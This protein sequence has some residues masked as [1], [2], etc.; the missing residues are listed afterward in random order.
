MQIKI[1]YL[2]NFNTYYSYHIITR[3]VSSSKLGCTR[4]GW[5][6]LSSIHRIIS[7]AI[8]GLFFYCTHFLVSGRKFFIIIHTL[9]TRLATSIEMVKFYVRWISIA[10]Y[11]FLN[12][13]KILMDTKVREECEDVIV[14][15]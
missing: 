4:I 2:P 11:L 13:L 9:R 15:H 6:P 1:K 5:G 8:S 12:P 3:D 7:Y 14:H 10:E